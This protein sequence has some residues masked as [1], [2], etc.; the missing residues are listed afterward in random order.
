[1][2]TETAELYDAIYSFKDYRTESRQ[3]A[4][5]I[6]QANPAARSV[7]DVACGTGEH[8]RWLI[9]DHGFSVD[10]LDL[11]EALLAVARRKVPDGT[12]VRADMARFD[13]GRQYDAVLCL[14]SSIAYLVTLER[15]G[16]ALDSFRRHLTPEGVAVVEP[17]FEPGVI[18][19]AR[20]TR[21]T[22]TLGAGRVERVSQIDVD[23]RVS[24]IHFRYTIETADGSRE[25]SEVHELGLFSEAEMQ[26]AFEAAGFTASFSSPG[27]MGRGLWV[28][29][30]A[31]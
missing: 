7:L 6:R 31:A 4:T 12:F 13:L 9:A 14:F 17:W 5:L 19:P 15:T 3:L 18:D 2:Y 23:G 1:M 21:H 22:G 29:R 24:R 28:A 26:R 16:S 20:V 10:G 25:S 27:L 11:D 30:P 8:A